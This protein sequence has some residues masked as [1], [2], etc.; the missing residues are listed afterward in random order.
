MRHM[1]GIDVLHRQKYL[2]AVASAAA[3][4]NECAQLLVDMQL[5]FVVFAFS[6]LF[7]STRWVAKRKKKNTTGKRLY[8][9]NEI[10]AQNECM[11]AQ[12]IVKKVKERNRERT[13]RIKKI[14]HSHSGNFVIL[15]VRDSTA[16]RVHMV[17]TYK[18]IGWILHG[19]VALCCCC[20]CWVCVCISVECTWLL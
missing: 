1:R 20:C 19:V 15:S 13:N 7:F 8:N 16:N 5:Q 6:A 9:Q 4:Y 17:N 12:K 18:C 3:C 11:S 10:L 14:A 2:A